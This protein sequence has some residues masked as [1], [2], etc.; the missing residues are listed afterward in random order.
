MNVNVGK[1]VK[2]GVGVFVL[3]WN[4]VNVKVGVAEFVGVEVMVGVKVMVPVKIIGV[5]LVVGVRGVPVDVML[6]VGV[7]VPSASGARINASA[8]R[9]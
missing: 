7:G 6:A 5:R 3:G 4:G 8:P 1:G 9:Q 2:V